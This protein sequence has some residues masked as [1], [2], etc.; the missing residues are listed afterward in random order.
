MNTTNKTLELKKLKLAGWTHCSRVRNNKGILLYDVGEC[1]TCRSEIIMPN[2]I[3][4]M[5]RTVKDLTEAGFIHRKNPPANESYP[6][7]VTGN[8]GCGECINE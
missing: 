4:I 2:T 3:K 7:N 8:Y 5:N 6:D 1:D